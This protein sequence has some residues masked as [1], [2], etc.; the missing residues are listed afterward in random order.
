[1]GFL[2]NLRRQVESIDLSSFELRP[3]AGN[4]PASPAEERSKSVTA[5]QEMVCQ[6]LAQIRPASVLEIYSGAGGYAEQAARSGSQVVAF[7]P[8]LTCVTRLYRETRKSAL[9]ILPLFMD[10]TK[11]TPARGLGS[12]DSIAATDRFQ[13]EMVLALGLLDHPA[14][15]KRIRLD[16]VIDGLSLFT[17]RWLL[18]EFTPRVSRLTSSSEPKNSTASSLE[19]AT[20]LLERRFG[21]IT[22][23][24]FQPEDRVVLLCEK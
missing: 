17:R 10:F 20:A 12:Y 7:D 19:E 3:G 8:D 15:D 23:L 1:M 14:F 18:L 5:Q 13:C 4:S 24:A 6:I 16:A 11:P 22:R 21:R 9:P 2:E